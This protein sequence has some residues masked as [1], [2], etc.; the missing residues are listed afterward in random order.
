MIIKSSPAMIIPVR[1]FTCAKVLS[2]KVRMYERLKAEAEEEASGG[3][4]PEAGESDSERAGLVGASVAHIL[5]RL[6]FTRVCCRRHM[7]TYVDAMDR[8]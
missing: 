3:A 5:D 4:E 7:L 8:I 1:C 6:G 2:D